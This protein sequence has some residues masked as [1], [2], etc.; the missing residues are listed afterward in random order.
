MLSTLADLLRIRIS[1]CGIIPDFKRVF[2]KT[3][4]VFIICLQ[5]Y[6]QPPGSRNV[7]RNSQNCIINPNNFFGGTSS[8]PHICFIG[9]IEA[10][11]VQMLGALN[12]GFLLILG[13]HFV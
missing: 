5:Y 12:P 13:F 6:P 7:M 3:M 4:L 2:P 1:L 11:K 8:L 9:Q 10:Y